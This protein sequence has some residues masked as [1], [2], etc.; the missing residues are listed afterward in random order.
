MKSRAVALLLADLSIT[1]THSRP[2]VSNDNPF[3]EAQFKTLKY[4]P[5]FPQRFGS[6]EDS[7]AFCRPFFRWY[8]TEHRHSGIAFMTPQDVHYGRATQILDT[9]SATMDAAFEAHPKR[10]K[11]KRPVLKTLPEAVWI[12]PPVNESSDQQEVA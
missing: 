12:N 4:R 5:E 6:L 1:K 8:T 2:H 9:R 7:R 11:N 3:S 10:F